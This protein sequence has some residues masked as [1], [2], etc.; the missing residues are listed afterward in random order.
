MSFEKNRLCQ[1]LNIKFPIIQAGMVWCSGWEL[2]STISNCGG[3][4]VIGAGS[5]Y[6]N[7]LDMHIQKCKANTAKPF[8]VNLPLL[9]PQIEE[10]I[11]IILKNK[12]P[13]VITSAGSPKKYTLIFKEAGI[14]VLH[15]V[16]SS[17]F[18]LKSQEAGV[19]AI[20][21]EGFE[22]GGHNGKEET[23]TLCLIPSVSQRI[24]IPL[25][26]A[27]GIYSGKSMMAAMILGADGVQIGS[28]FVASIESSAH[29]SFKQKVV[30]AKEGDTK[31][32]LKK[33]TPV[34]LLHNEFASEIQ[35]MENKGVNEEILKEKLGKGRA[36]LGMFEGDLVEGE[37]EIGQC[38]ALFSEIKPAKDI[39]I[40]ILVEFEGSKNQVQ[41]Y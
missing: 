36:K 31:L 41:N 29:P 13:V 2:A 25:V 6:P 3:L 10:H 38:S 8:A 14:K 26:A 24:D 20:I 4:G 1:L 7:V 18:A 15:V 33:L 28:R 39:F 21:A 35:T 5:M 9:Y 19:D 22:A 40:E 17:A 12:V 27:G 11:A 34:R 23:T 16:S 32:S 37:L 30:E